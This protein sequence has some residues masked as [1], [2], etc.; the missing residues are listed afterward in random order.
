MPFMILA[1]MDDS[2]RGEKVKRGELV[3]FDALYGPAVP[4]VRRAIGFHGAEALIEP[5][6]ELEGAVSPTEVVHRI[7]RGSEARRRGGA[8]AGVLRLEQALCLRRPRHE[9]GVEAHPGARE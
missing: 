9:L 5:F 7:V 4:P 1:C 2:L 3:I 8:H 6:A